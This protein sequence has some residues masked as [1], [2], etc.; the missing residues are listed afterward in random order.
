MWDFSMP[1]QLDNRNYE[2]EVDENSNINPPPGGDSQVYK[3]Q[4]FKKSK[5]VSFDLPFE[6]EDITDQVRIDDKHVLW[7]LHVNAC[8]K[9]EAFPKLKGGPIY[10]Q[11]TPV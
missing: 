10:R 1:P 7:L 8:P 6:Y 3:Q 5:Q 9:S 2:V 4:H 11:E